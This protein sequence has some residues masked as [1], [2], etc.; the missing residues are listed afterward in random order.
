MTDSAE[1]PSSGRPW[2]SFA[3]I[4]AASAGLALLALILPWLAALDLFAYDAWH[5]LLGS[6]AEVT[7]IAI[8]AIDDASLQRFGD[9]PLPFWQPQLGA[10]IDTLRAAGVR[11]IGIDLIQVASAESWLKAIGAGDTPAGRSYEAPYR[12]ALAQGGVV[13]AAALP[14]EAGGPETMPPV[15]HQLLLPG[16]PED[17][18]LVNLQGDSDGFIR[19]LAP[20]LATETPALSFAARLARAAENLPPSPENIAARF[21]AG[22]RTVQLI[23]FAGPPK[24]VPRVSLASLVAPDALQRPEVLALRGKVVVIAAEATGLQD[25]HLT[26]YARALTGAPP[27]LMSGGEIY[28]QA[29]VI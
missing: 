7:R 6:R 24:H 22:A 29:I 12:A 18:G 5:R 19:Q 17:L 3:G 20:V 11:A 23:P 21:G 1:R 27:S 10:A 13:L 8:V 16:G 14:T 4:A 28:A 26:P 9:T 2:R 15:E 25:F